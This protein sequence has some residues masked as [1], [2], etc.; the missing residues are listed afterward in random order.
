M[1]STNLIARAPG[2]SAAAE[3]VEATLNAPLIPTTSDASAQRETGVE[4]GRHRT[5]ERP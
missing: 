3:A 2:A 1:M 5:G 4:R